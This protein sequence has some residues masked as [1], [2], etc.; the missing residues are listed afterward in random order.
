[1]MIVNRLDDEVDLLQ[2]KNKKTWT[3][4][5]SSLSL[6]AL[7]SRSKGCRTNIIVTPDVIILILTASLM[8]NSNMGY[9]I[10]LTNC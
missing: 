10:S 8:V 5:S 9:R 4:G 2:L 3:E 7:S 1:M 6:N